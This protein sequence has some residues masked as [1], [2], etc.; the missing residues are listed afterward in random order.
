MSFNET[1][2]NS[3]YKKSLCPELSIK[4]NIFQLFQDFLYIVDNNKMDFIMKK[5][6]F[7]ILFLIICFSMVSCIESDFNAKGIME[8]MEAEDGYV[9]YFFCYDGKYGIAN[10]D[11]DVLTLPKYDAIKYFSEDGYFELKKANENSEDTIIAI[12]TKEHEKKVLI[13]QNIKDYRKITAKDKKRYCFQTHYKEGEDKW[14][15]GVYDK[16]WNVIV[17]CTDKFHYSYYISETKYGEVERFYNSNGIERGDRRLP[18]SVYIN[19]EGEVDYVKDKLEYINIYEMYQS[20]NDKL[21]LFVVFRFYNDFL[22]DSSNKKYTY[23]GRDDENNKIFRY[24]YEDNGFISY[25]YVDDNYNVKSSFVYDQQF[26]KDGN[27]LIWHY[28]DILK[29]YYDD[30]C[31]DIINML[32]KEIDDDAKLFAFMKKA[33]NNRFWNKEI[34]EDK[35]IQDYKDAHEYEIERLQENLAS[36]LEFYNIKT[37]R[38]RNRVDGTGTRSD[39]SVNSWEHRGWYLSSMDG[40]DINSG[41][42]MGS[43]GIIKMQFTIYDDHLDVATEADVQKGKA[44]K[45]SFS[46][47]ENGWR[48]YRSVSGD[49]RW[50]MDE[51]YYV[52]SNYDIKYIMNTSEFPIV[53]DGESFA[54]YQKI[55]SGTSGGFSS[56]GSV[57][58]S[59]G[60]TNTSRTESTSIPRTDCPNCKGGRTVYER[61]ISPATFGLKTNIKRCNECGKT[62]DANS[63]AHFHDR[64][65][66][67]H[68]TGYLD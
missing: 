58:Y 52:N 18:L 32:R 67:C 25:Y 44:S 5:L 53:K 63:I 20:S 62:Y 9:W 45:I 35:A 38:G 49:G 13:Q 65:N 24:V 17:P 36:T 8:K 48:V 56:S 14:W 59:S 1:L 2:I 61:S 54:S 7:S 16:H 23:L 46:G 64:C 50:R 37:E 42:H 21:G 41:V 39:N 33:A 29:E 51:R 47:M 6:Y 30:Y 12:E 15:Y 26:D 28:Y 55:S 4:L 3:I 40:I 19:S 27:H 10:E 43:S 34:D 66:T 22:I 31:E 60:S 68:G 11:G 57:N